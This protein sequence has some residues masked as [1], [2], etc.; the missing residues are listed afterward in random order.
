MTNSIKVLVIDDDKEDFAIIQDLFSRIKSSRFTLTWSPNY[1]DALEQIA[2]KEHDIYLI[3][4]RLGSENGLGLI[5]EAVKI[6]IDVPLILLTGLNDIEIDKQAMSAGAFDYLEK[7][8][9][10]P[11]LL[12]R[13]I[14]YSIEHAKDSKRIKQLNLHL[15]K[16]GKEKYRN[17]FQNSLVA[18]HTKDAKTLKVI[19]VNDFSIRMFGYKSKKEYLDNFDT[20]THFVNPAER[21]DIVK[22]LKKE[23]GTINQSIHEMKKLDGSHFWANIFMKLNSERSLFQVV[24][25]DV[26][27]QVHSQEELENKVKI[28][29]LELTESL[30]REKALNESTSRF[31]AAA[32]H[33]FRTPLTT[34][35]SSATLIEKYSGAQQEQ[36]RLKHTQRISASVRNLT[37][38]LDDCLSLSQFDK[39]SIQAHSEIF[40]LPEFLKSIREETEGMLS[41][42][43]QY[44]QYRHEGDL[45]T[46]HAK[47][48]LK[49][50][51]FNLISNASKYS[52]ENSEI[53]LYSSIIKEK[54]TIIVQ[55]KGIG[56][57][58]AD[59]KNLFQ[60]FFR[61]GNVGNI[62]GTGLGLC[63]VGKYV[64]L[65]HGTIKFSSKP[66]KGTSF[67]LNLPKSIEE[68]L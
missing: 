38:I 23:G 16:I 49:N 12:E 2:R 6:G 10:T 47:K 1:T 65:I 56:I 22:L 52:P 67:T 24:I 68:P 20:S 48:I 15:V 27:E 39:G 11:S 19:E 33:E 35:L 57:P 18:M 43:N 51:L 36:N 9:L 62:Q 50:I 29:T 26:T 32:S 4:Y 54:V 55:D 7:D 34:I 21:D 5:K 45:M 25:V 37:V 42:K 44:L 66:N 58:K 63:L 46:K 53:A 28:R 64:E 13:T 40:N 61:A 60:E 41:K 8:L 30:A 14:R 3:D 17:L 31:I 59:Q